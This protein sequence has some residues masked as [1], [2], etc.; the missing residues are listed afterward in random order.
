MKSSPF[1][2]LGLALALG[3]STAHATLIGDTITLI[4]YGPNLT[5]VSQTPAASL[6][7]QA[8]I[9]DVVYFTEFGSNHYSI[10]PEANSISV[11]FLRTTNWFFTPDFNG[12]V[13]SGINDTITGV[14]VSTNLAGWDNSRISFTAHSVFSNWQ[15][16]TSNSNNF[17]NITLITTATGDGGTTAAM[18]GLAIL[19]LA[20]LRRWVS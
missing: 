3:C 15:G 12:L 14:V 1:R 19:G 5:A 6:V 18:L 17:F 4:H 20:A 2:I 16:I 13:A 9:G 11:Q 8:G 10:N 7:V